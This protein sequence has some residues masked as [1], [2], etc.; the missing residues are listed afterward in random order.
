MRQVLSLSLPQ[1]ATKEIKDLSKKRG[2]D[3]VSAYVKYLITLDKDLISEEELLEDI[4]IG[5]KEYK[6]GK[7]VVAK[8]MAELL[9]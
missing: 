9:K 7:T 5:Q 1:S 2:F 4:K 8:S 3:S 6:Q